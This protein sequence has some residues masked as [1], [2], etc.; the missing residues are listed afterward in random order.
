MVM[1]EMRVVWSLDEFLRVPVECIFTA[2][3][4][5]IISLSLIFRFPCGCFG[6]NFHAANQIFNHGCLLL[7]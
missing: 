1:T 2:V 4:A 7:S 6:I 5:E 3:A